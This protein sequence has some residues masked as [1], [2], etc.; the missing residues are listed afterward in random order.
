MAEATLLETGASTET[1]ESATTTTE[2]TTETAAQVGLLNPDGTF[3]ENWL[4]RLPAD[5]EAG[6]PTLGKYKTFGDL[7]KAHVSLQTLLGQKANAITIPTDKSTP[8]EV[9]AF[10]KAIGAPETAEAY[11]LKPEKLPDGVEWDEELAKGFATIAHKHGVPAAA[12][13]EIT[14]RFIASEEARLQAQSQLITQKLEDGRAALKKEFGANYDANLSTASRLAKTVGLD[15]TAVGLCDPNVVKAL[16]RFAG[17]ISEDKLVAAGATAL[18]GT[19]SAKDI[20]T[21]PS[22]P[23]H[24][25]YQEGDPAVVAQVRDMLK[26]A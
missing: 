2:T 14:A 1:T 17:M 19:M 12:M 9:A 15:P 3:A 4:D 11:N 26:T 5:L 20:M 25:R 13:Q 23:L 6:K 22:N 21:N 10:R 24:K 18:P 7:A 8:E 16:V